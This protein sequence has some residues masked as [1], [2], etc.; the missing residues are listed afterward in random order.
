MVEKISVQ[1]AL[2]GT[3]EIKRQLAG[4]SEAGQK[5]FADISAAAAKAGGF[6]RLDPTLVAQKFNQFGITATNDIN[7]IT[8][9]LQAAGKTE[10]MVSGVQKMEQ[11]V[12]Q[13]SN[14][15]T[16]ATAAFGLTRRE[17]G[18]LGRVL[19]ELNLGAVGGELAVL[20]RVGAAF[21]PTGLAIGAV[22][23][24]IGGVVAALA[25]FASQASETE[26]ALTQ[27]QKA[28][29]VSFENLSAMQQV[30]AAGGTSAKDFAQDMARLNQ[31]VD[32]AGQAAAIRRADPEWVK[33]A[34][35]IKSVVQQFDNLGAG[36]RVI[37]SPLTTLDTKVQAIKESLAKVK[38]EARTFKL[39]EIFKGLDDIDRMRIGAALGLK[40][41][42]IAT[43]SQ[44]S[45][46]LKQMQAEAQR[47]GLTLTTGNQ[48]AL[49]KMAQ[50]WFE[51]TGLLSALFQKIGAI[52]APAFIELLNFFK[53]ILKSIAQD[54]E[55]LPLD[56]AIANLGTRLAPAFQV[57]GTIL[58]PILIQ[59]GNALGQALIEGIKLGV[60]GGIAGILA[61]LQNELEAN[62][63]ILLE[64]WKRLKA[65]F[66]FGDGG[67]ASS[68]AQ[69]QE[70]FAG[71]G[72]IG[73]RGSGTSDSNLAWVSRGEHIM[74]ARAV[75]QPG[76]LA[77][78]EALRRSGGN[79]SRVLDGMGRFALGGLVP[80]PAMAFAGGGA[81]GGMSNVTIQFPGLPD[82]GGLRASTATVD[83]L[84]R[85]AALAQ[86]R[87]GG[88]KPSRY[89]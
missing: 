34:N 77:F 80:R 17:I 40:P 82:I 18:A 19:R 35:D 64:N 16:G 81:V 1:I 4:V 84:R 73:G 20:G 55:T 32:E 39:A 23:V 3:E 74:P 83:E 48:Q 68:D 76:V 29:G 2:E 57:I 14:A 7:K 79:L 8:R 33:W 89:S 21:G 59:M 66:G 78:L 42:E 43:L 69:P 30:F 52:A 60:Q 15:A 45:A 75:A 62:F 44:G 49:Q 5:C 11:G 56:E 36:A 26:K 12:R 13:L 65:K 50:A 31:Q 87:S 71:G 58:S 54:F 28:T 37:F 67:G 24:A 51:F 6:D 61:N 25:K 86:V 10:A 63:K 22:A 53:E 27:L 46:A 9:A 72:F 85:A 47:L 41:E 70:G 88:R 38:G